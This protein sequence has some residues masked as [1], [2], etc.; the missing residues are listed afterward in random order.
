MSNIESK[1][2]LI[3]S[4]GTGGGHNSAAR[5]V[6]EYLLEKNVEADFIEYLEITSKK[7]KDKINELYISSTHNN[8]VV[9]EKIYGLGKLYQKTKLK[10]PVYQLNWLNRNRLY[11]YIKENKYDYIVATHLFP[12]Q[13]LTAI[14]K[15]H[16]IHFMAVATDYV[17]I[18]FWEETDPDYFIIPN[19][20][21]IKDFEKKGIAKEKLLPLG[22]PVGKAFATNYD[23]NDAREELKLNQNEKYILILTGSM[24]FGNVTKMLEE[25]INK[26]KDVNFIVSC[27]TNNK[28]HDELQE[29]Y[30][31]RNNIIIIPFTKNINIYMKASDIILSKPGGLTTTEIA[32]LR[33][34]FI[35]TMP[36]PGC[37]NDNA[38][39]FESRK[40]SL[41]CNTL[42]EVVEK[43]KELIS[44]EKL[45]KELVKNQEKYI[46]IK[47]SEKIANK[48]IEEIEK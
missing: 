45:Q 19:K 8:G 44:D 40:M 2:V 38:N 10:S 23:K 21:L 4:C 17:S 12:A 39:F 36:I 48:I 18:P 6:R 46:D 34:P 20:D 28:L 7:I 33:K 37:E 31:N 5:A 35:H 14:K 27:G 9:F 42:E 3:L 29:K 16:E 26:V 25:L 11:E 32:T 24:G 30:K 13:A 41:K 22:I 1:K 47:A 15:E 43:T